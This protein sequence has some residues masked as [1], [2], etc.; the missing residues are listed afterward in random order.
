MRGLFRVLSFAVLLALPFSTAFAA[1]AYVHELQGTLT[2]QYGT[3]AP[4]ALKIGDTLD[5]GVTLSTGARS[6]AIVKFEDGQLVVLQ[7]NTRFAVREYRYDSSQIKDSNI[8]FQLVQGGLRF[9]TGMIGATNR[10]AFTLNVGTATI[11]VRGTDGTVLYD[12][13]AQMITLAVTNGAGEILNQ[14][15]ITNI[16]AGQATSGTLT[17]ALA[18][19]TPAAQLGAAQLTALAQTSGVVLPNNLPVMVAASALAAAAREAARVATAAAAAPGATDAQR[20][21]AAQAQALAD[22]TLQTAIAEAVNAYTAAVQ[23]GGVTPTPPAPPAATGAAAATQQTQ[24]LQDILKQLTP[25][26]TPTP[27]PVSQ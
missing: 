16:P 12:A 9:V 1:S 15:V 20:A 21:L 14:N 17:A 6:M 3:A 7:P 8:V 18:A 10:N 22:S 27:T 23:A 5:S 13:I 2:G 24:Q 11:G 25:T 19:A 26:P 4:R